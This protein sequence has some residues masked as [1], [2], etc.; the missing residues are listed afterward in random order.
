MLKKI[1]FILIILTPLTLS[2]AD[3]EF[4]AD[5]RQLLYKG[6]AFPFYKNVLTPIGYYGF[7]IFGSNPFQAYGWYKLDEKELSVIPGHDLSAEDIKQG[8]AFKHDKPGN[9]PADWIYFQDSKLWARPESFF[10][11]LRLWEL[12]YENIEKL[13]TDIYNPLKKNKFY[14]II[15]SY[16]TNDILDVQITLPAYLIKAHEA[17][18]HDFGTRRQLI[19]YAF[20]FSDEAVRKNH[21]IRIKYT[22]THNRTI[23]KKYF[24]AYPEE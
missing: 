1:I 21:S 2:A 5:S 15:T 20:A 10:K 24:I 14:R 3:W 7:A 16:L 11:L 9:L 13:G 23:E 6:E 18:I 19:F 22:L 17:D 4:K 8:W 12:Y